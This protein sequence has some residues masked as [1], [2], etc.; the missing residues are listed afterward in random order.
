[1]SKTYSLEPTKHPDLFRN[2]DRDGNWKEYFHA[3]TKTYLRGVTTILD[4]GYAKT[5][6]F[7]QYLLKT[8]PEEA[9]RKLN[10][11]GDKG[12]AVHQA[13]AGLLATGSFE[14]NLQ[15]LA[16]D[17]KNT[18][19]LSND[20]WDCLLSFGEFWNRHKAVCLASEEAVFNL[21]PTAKYAGTLDALVIL[22]Q[23]CGVKACSCDDFIGKI[24][25]F[26]WKSGGGIYESYGAQVAAYACADNLTVKPDYT[27]ILRV[28]TA[29][30]T[31]G[32]YQLEIY[33]REETVKH[34]G[35]F[36]AAMTIDNATYKPFD[37]E[38]EI[39]DIPDSI[40]LT[41][42]TL[43]DQPR[44]LMGF[45]VL[46]SKPSKQPAQSSG[47]PKKQANGERTKDR[48]QAGRAAKTKA[49]NQAA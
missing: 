4:R 31:T 32:G 10:A 23:A 43:P 15:V 6:A 24:G 12:D 7:Y 40:T 38:K 35:E 48:R 21:G 14:R 36:I 49:R 33:D 30:K 1:M 22:T 2:V 9:E 19:E 17:N 42:T 27:A 8:N 25:L 26:D 13:I 44:T 29:H 18:R 41:L 34:F 11:A 5:H 20:E 39:Q 16:G 28:G 47:K 3:P 46:E 37:P 45:P